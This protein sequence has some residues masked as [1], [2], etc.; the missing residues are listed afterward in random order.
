MKN[1]IFI[2]DDDVNI[3]NLLRSQLESNGYDVETFLDGQDLLA[4]FQVNPCN[5]IITDIMMPNLN[6]YDLCR[7]IRK[8]SDLPFIMISAKDE[9]IDR[10]LGLELGSDD[11]ISKPFSLRELSVKVRNML[12][13]LQPVLNDNDE[14]LLCK[15]IKINKKNRT[16]ILCDEQFQA[17]TKEYDLLEFLVLNKNQAFSRDMLIENVWSYDYYGDSRQV[18]HLIKRLRKKMLLTN[19]EFKI[20]TLW[21]FGYKVED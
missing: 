2:A 11:Y 19:C 7:E 18:D 17:T 1:K 9:E 14:I 8:T 16:I 6:G 15:D 3:C 4:N 21:G 13:R 12:K 5:L 20:E 10:I